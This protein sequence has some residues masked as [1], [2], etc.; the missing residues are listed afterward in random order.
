MDALVEAVFR[1]CPG[2][3]DPAAVRELAAGTGFFRPDEVEVAVQ[4]A[5]EWLAKGPASGYNFIISEIG[6]KTVGYVCFGLIPCSLVSY[7]I[8]WVVVDR[9][10]QGRG[11]GSRLLERCEQASR[12]LGARSVFVETSGRERYLPTRRFY[13]KA[14]Y[15]EAARL[16]DFYD[17]GDAKIIYRK[18]LA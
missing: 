10:F 6:G 2:E 3:S 14:G 7:D 5:D 8:Y 13:L 4:L 17:L 16:P 15:A 12:R 9:G 1:D 18:D 11:L